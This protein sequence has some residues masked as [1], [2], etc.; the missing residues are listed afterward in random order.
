MANMRYLLISASFAVVLIAQDN[1]AARPQDTFCQVITV[2]AIDARSHQVCPVVPEQMT[3]NGV[4][5]VPLSAEHIDG[6]RHVVLLIHNGYRVALEI[7]EPISQP[8]RF[9]LQ[10]KNS[11][12]ENIEAHYPFFI[13]PEGIVY[14]QRGDVSTAG[15]RTSQCPERNCKNL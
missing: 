3:I 11:R 8:R 5:A 2:V 6:P 15:R 9:T 4:S 12:G 13:L 10:L 14:L 1:A 7:R